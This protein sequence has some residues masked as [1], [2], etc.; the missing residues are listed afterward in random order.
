M[1]LTPTGSYALD[2]PDVLVIG[3]EVSHE[4]IK[5]HDQGLLL[6]ALARPFAT[7]FGQDAYPTL[8]RKAGALLHSLCRNH[9]LSNCDERTG[10]GCTT[11]FLM[12]N[13][14]YVEAPDQGDIVERCLAAPEDRVSAEEIATVLAGWEAPMPTVL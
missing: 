9:A 2:V 8:F 10:W 12:A 14:T 7:A 3:E 1:R 5:I 4:E 11:V 13:G 6:S